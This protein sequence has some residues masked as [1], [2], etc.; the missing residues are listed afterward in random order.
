MTR[1]GK[2]LTAGL[3]TALAVLAYAATHEGWDVYLIGGS[4]RWAAGAIGILG[5]ATCALG[6]RAKTAMTTVL[7]ALGIAAVVLFAVALATGSLAPLSLLV[8]DI[9]LLFLVS[10]FEHAGEIRGRPVPH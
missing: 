8:A 6:S 5:I 10:S 9:V 3:L 2:D 1:L 4:H 7:S